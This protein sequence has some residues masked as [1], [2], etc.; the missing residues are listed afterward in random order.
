LEPE[1]GLEA[2]EHN[3]SDSF[4]PVVTTMEEVEE[5]ASTDSHE[6]TD[7]DP[8]EEFLRKVESLIE[9]V[10]QQVPSGMEKHAQKKLAEV[11]HILVLLPHL[12]DDADRDALFAK[13]GLRSSVCF[14]IPRTSI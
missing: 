2:P 12:D 4:T 1:R 7:V 5:T 9:L 10:R 13:L 8:D 6:I 11:L 14:K 3:T